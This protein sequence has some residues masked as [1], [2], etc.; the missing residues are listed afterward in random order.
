MFEKKFSFRPTVRQDVD[1]LVVHVEEAT[2][3]LADGHKRP[4]A[5][6]DVRIELEMLRHVAP[7]SQ[8]QDLG[9]RLLLMR[10]LGTVHTVVVLTPRS[11]RIGVLLRAR[12]RL[13]MARLVGPERRCAT[14]NARYAAA[15][16]KRIASGGE[17]AARGRLRE[18]E[19]ASSQRRRRRRHC[20][21]A[22]GA[23]PRSPAAAVIRARFGLSDG[24]VVKATASIPSAVSN[25]ITRFSSVS[26]TFLP[27]VP[28][29]CN[30]L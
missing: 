10:H 19:R 28:D 8:Q 3:T 12:H 22:R 1:G 26:Q 7:S 25:F 2:E 9:R 15:S 29:R 18:P 30:Y 17:R 6:E 20:I 13:R 16:E 11:V 24:P 5:G 27:G 21:A 23:N 14:A 4:V